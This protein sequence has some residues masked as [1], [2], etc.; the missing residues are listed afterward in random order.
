MIRA[1]GSNAQKNVGCGSAAVVTRFAEDHL[2]D[3]GQGRYGEIGLG[4]IR[5]SIWGHIDR[6]WNTVIGF[7]ERLSQVL[8][9][10]LSFFA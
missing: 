3:K 7:P 9:R 4:T 1:Y 2:I 6:S 8:S 10:L 5:E